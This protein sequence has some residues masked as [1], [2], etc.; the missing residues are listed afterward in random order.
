MNTVLHFTGSCNE[1]LVKSHWPLF[2]NHPFCFNALS[3][4]CP[5]DFLFSREGGNYSGWCEWFYLMVNGKILESHLSEEKGKMKVWSGWKEAFSNLRSNWM[6]HA[7]C[8][9][10]KGSFRETKVWQNYVWLWQAVKSTNWHEW[11]L[12]DV[13]VRFTASVDVIISMLFLKCHKFSQR[14]MF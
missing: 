3:L 13:W 10:K 7:A 8:T 11:L 1:W 4:F 6:L 5:G 2:C 14:N 9:L 12:W